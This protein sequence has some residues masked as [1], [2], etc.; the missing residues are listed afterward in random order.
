MS[1]NSLKC[2]TVSFCCMPEALTTL[3]DLIKRFLEK[4][5]MPGTSLSASFFER[6]LEKNVLLIDQISLTDC[7]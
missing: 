3:F 4:K 6:I 2:S 7:L 1:I 5:Q